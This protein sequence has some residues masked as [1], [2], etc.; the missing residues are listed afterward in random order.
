MD[1]GP[2]P[3]CLRYHVADRSATNS[4]RPTSKHQLRGRRLRS[5]SAFLANQEGTAK[6]WSFSLDMSNQHF[7]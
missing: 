5:L 3:T 1:T 2:R 4:R 6:P 7:T